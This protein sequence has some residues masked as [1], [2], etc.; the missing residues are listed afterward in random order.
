VNYK[1][2]QLKA[3]LAKM[4]PDILYFGGHQDIPDELYWKLKHCPLQ[5][6][7]LDT[8]LLHLCQEARKYNQL[9]SQLTSDATWQE[10]VQELITESGKLFTPHGNSESSLCAK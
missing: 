2:F 7:V 4:L 6:L 5:K 8:E 9:K 10:Q 1:D 3:A